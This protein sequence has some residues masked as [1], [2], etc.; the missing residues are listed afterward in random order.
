[1]STVVAYMAI[2]PQTR[3]PL[4][5]HSNGTPLTRARLETKVG[6]TLAGDGMD[7]SLYTG[8][9]FGIGAA[10]SAARAGIPDSFNQTLGHWQSSAFQRYIRTPT[11]TL[12][13]FPQSLTQPLTNPGDH[14]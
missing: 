11:S 4:F 12:L 10:S 6:A 13:A 9:S 2:C 14:T 3:G 7:L 5:I 8:H 1:M